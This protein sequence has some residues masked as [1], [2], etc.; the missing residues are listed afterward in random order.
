MDIDCELVLE[1]TCNDQR[2]E[3]GVL[4]TS[5]CFWIDP[6]WTGQWV[7]GTCH[8]SKQQKMC[9]RVRYTMQRMPPAS[10]RRPQHGGLNPTVKLQ[11][12]MPTGL[13][14]D[15]RLPDFRYAS[16]FPVAHLLEGKE[17]L[18]CALWN[19]NEAMCN[20]R[21]GEHLQY[22]RL[23]VR[24]LTRSVLP[25][26]VQVHPMRVLPSIES[27]QL[28][29]DLAVWLRDTLRTLYPRT[30]SIFFLMRSI[31]RN[32][33]QDFMFVDAQA[34]FQTNGTNLPPVLGPYVLCN[35]L[36][37]RG[38]T[39]DSAETQLL[40]PKTQES[41]VELLALMRDVLMCFTLCPREGRYREDMCIGH[42][43]ED[44]P[45]CL[46]FTPPWL[47]LETIFG[48]DDCE[49]MGQQGVVHVVEVFK[50][51]ARLESEEV[52]C[53]LVEQQARPLLDLQAG[54][55]RRL[56][57]V[58]V[59][60]GHM[61]LDGRL[62][63]HMCD[64]E[65]LITQFSPGVKVVKQAQPQNQQ[66]P[67]GHSFGMLLYEAKSGRLQGAML[68]ENT[69]IECIETTGKKTRFETEVGGELAK[70]ALKRRSVMNARVCLLHEEEDNLYQKIC[71]GNGVIFFT[72]RANGG[73]LE[74]GASPSLVSQCFYRF[75][76]GE[77]LPQRSTDYAVLVPVEKLL[78]AL[79]NGT[80]PWGRHPEIQHADKALRAWRRMK[81]DLKAFARLWMPPQDTEGEYLRRMH[82][83]WGTIQQADML[84]SDRP[85]I[86]LLA[87][88]AHKGPGGVPVAKL[89]DEFEKWL[90]RYERRMQVVTHEFMWSRLYLMF[91][92]EDM[93][94]K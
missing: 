8:A 2:Q 85:R 29:F 49:G 88:A 35:A 48:R 23:Q 41:V 66:Y 26:G 27:H 57:R 50:G 20:C 43:A 79:C 33:F 24:T 90:K 9:F 37:V 1:W 30:N 28:V 32:E 38:L 10:L 7:Q 3:Y 51:L 5:V 21:N 78:A 71:V 74:Y 64:G 83:G 77:A 19:E 6:Y 86:G 81:E 13:R 44:Q 62:E 69:G 80:G 47:H 70:I 87:T 67:E 46:Q 55:L 59:A 68:L 16:S 17:G 89:P 94:Q 22:V 72:Q 14:S 36:I 75:A 63:A 52:A 25:A 58:C 31:G 61:F 15:T 34:M 92:K 4:P 12:F 54:T 84:T 73:A 60:I 39:L 93:A 11:F 40:R 45:E 82:Q 42:Q 18:T 65:S 91:E 76:S 53:R 56:V